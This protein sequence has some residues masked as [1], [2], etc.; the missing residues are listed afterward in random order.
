MAGNANVLMVSN[1]DLES[2]DV[3]NRLRG[4]FFLSSAGGRS[5]LDRLPT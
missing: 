3:V 5:G 2:Y 4:A 1:I